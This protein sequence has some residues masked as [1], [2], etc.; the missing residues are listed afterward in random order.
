MIWCPCLHFIDIGHFFFT[1]LNGFCLVFFRKP[2]K[3]R[4]LFHFL[5]CS[6][7][8]VWLIIAASRRSVRSRAFRRRNTKSLWSTGVQSQFC[9]LWVF[10]CM[11][12]LCLRYLL[13]KIY[14]CIWWSSLKWATHI[15]GVIFSLFLLVRDTF[16]F[17]W[18]CGVFLEFLLRSVHDWV[19][20][21]Q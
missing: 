3:L 12:L 9:I 20:L 4:L 1:G 7:H 10:R 19:L 18:D 11:S 8:F 21:E 6:C 15:D 16:L 17:E 13:C 2:V 5:R 14:L